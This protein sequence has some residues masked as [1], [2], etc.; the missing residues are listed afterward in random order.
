MIRFWG[1]PKYAQDERFAYELFLREKIADQ[2]TFPQNFGRFN[3]EN[4][5]ILLAQTVKAVSKETQMLSINLDQPEFARADYLETLPQLQAQLPDMQLCVE[6]TER[7]YGVAQAALVSAA[8]TYQEA[9]LWVCIDDVGTG[10]NQ[11]SLVQALSPY[12]QEYKFALQN[13][14]D[15]KTS[16]RWCR[17]YYN[18]GANKP[19]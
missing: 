6:L 14:H 12:V 15:K 17:H 5:A 1:Q 2:W 11:L 13:F 8:R 19:S 3:A 16:S 10:D 7:P 9:G 4:I 18:F